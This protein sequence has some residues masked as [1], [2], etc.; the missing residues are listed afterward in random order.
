MKFYEFL[1]QAS[2]GIVHTAGYPVTIQDGIKRNILK[3]VPFV[4]VPAEGQ[5]HS[6]PVDHESRLD[7]PFTDCFFEI[8]GRPL[9]E[10]E[11]N[12]SR[13]YLNGV[14][15]HEIGPRDY[16]IMCLMSVRSGGP[17]TIYALPSNE[18][19]TPLA[20]H[21][22]GIVAALLDRLTLED[23]G[24]SN[25][26]HAI[27]VRTSEG[28][29][30]HRINRVVHVAP[31]SAH[32]VAQSNSSKEI[33][34]SHRFEVRGHWRRTAALGKDREGIYCVEG[35]TWVREHVRGPEHVPLIKKT[36]VVSA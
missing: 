30:Q 5:E 28:K 4:F 12:K 14:Y 27:K 35:Y 23:A 20:D 17:Y 19:A 22:R 11:E 36:R 34:W 33:D 24:V 31:R 21:I 9:L 25:P 6:R 3:A 16:L 10:F 1:K 18:R 7:L 32:H 15:I 29:I 13:G 26:R 8:L 2:Y